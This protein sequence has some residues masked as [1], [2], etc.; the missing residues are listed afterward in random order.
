MIYPPNISSFSYYYNRQ[1]VTNFSSVLFNT[2]LKALKHG[3]HI[4]TFINV[5]LDLI[6]HHKEDIEGIL[7]ESNMIT[8]SFLQASDVLFIS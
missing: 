2:Q 8:V 4:F 3:G 1:I 5:M 6:L 7:V